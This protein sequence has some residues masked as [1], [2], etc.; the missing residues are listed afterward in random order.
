[1]RAF[2]ENFDW[3]EKARKKYDID[4]VL[5]TWDTRGGKLFGHLGYGRM[6]TVFKDGISDAFPPSWF[7][8]GLHV[9]LPSLA[10]H[11]KRVT[12]Q[13]ITHALI[14]K[15]LSVTKLHIETRLNFSWFE[16]PADGSIR[17]DPFSLQMLYKI[18]QADLLRQNIETERGRP[19][20]IVIRA[21]PDRALI[22]LNDKLM[23]EAIDG[24]IYVN[25]L[26]PGIGYA[27][28]FFA[29]GN[30]V[31]MSSYSSF[32]FQAYMAGKQ[33]NWR[34]I[35]FELFHYLNNLG[36][37][38]ATYNPMK[39]F[40]NE[41][42]LNVDDMSNI[43]TEM[44]VD[45]DS[46]PEGPWLPQDEPDKSI[47]VQHLT[48]AAGINAGKR[49]WSDPE[50]V[51]Y[52]QNVASK[53]LPERDCGIFYALAMGER[54]EIGNDIKL[55]ALALGML[56]FVDARAPDRTI[57]MFAKKLGAALPA[58]DGISFRKTG[59]IVINNGGD[60]DALVAV[61]RSVLE[62]PRWAEKIRMLVARHIAPAVPD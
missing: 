2:E 45:L 1:M 61:F 7:D 38:L 16:R 34:S 59:E 33:K 44:L 18:W 30:S 8:Y 62:N 6:K 46:I 47:V 24:T 4:V 10:E 39:E 48:L 29:M 22:G 54:A 26:D 60:H 5:S 25:R 53:F 19:F 55:L 11:G 14:E 56:S 21:R 32:F 52:L 50:T 3:L 13:Q 23:R 9:A 35:H 36:V 17:N 43:L 20:D 15:K 31:N 27:G 41:E 40:A 42:I 49:K 51:F 28:D 57:L 58:N 37:P 12:N